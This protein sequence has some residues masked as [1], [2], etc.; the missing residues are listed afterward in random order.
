MLRVFRQSLHGLP[1]PQQFFLKSQSLT[2]QFVWRA[3]AT[4]T[5][6]IPQALTEDQREGNRS[7]IH[8]KLSPKGKALMPPG[9]PQ[10]K[11]YDDECEV[12]AGDHTGRQQVLTLE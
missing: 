10:Q 12:T 6:P 1:Q 9:S 5:T 2:T 4:S 7:H 8:F 11:E 3:M